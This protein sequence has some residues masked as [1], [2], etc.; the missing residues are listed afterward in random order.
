MC[1][2]TIF[3]WILLI[4]GAVLAWYLALFLGLLANSLRKSLCPDEYMISGMC[5]GLFGEITLDV[6]LV[7][8]SGISAFFV[9]GSSALI[10]PAHKGAVA[11][12]AFLIGGGVAGFFLVDS[13]FVAWM[14]FVSAI[15]FGAAT[16][17]FVVRRYR[18]PLVSD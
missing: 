7:L 1:R 17:Y 5:T 16:C 14:E 18:S 10:A 3:R 4:P 8:F 15:T 2:L 13:Q 11:I 9:V 6:L 12:A